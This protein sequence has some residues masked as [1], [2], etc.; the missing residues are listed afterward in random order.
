VVEL[1]LNWSY[2]LLGRAAES[3]K[4]TQCRFACGVLP[5][6]ET[7]IKGRRIQLTLHRCCLDLPK[8]GLVDSW[9]DGPFL[10]LTAFPGARF[11]FGCFTVIGDVALQAA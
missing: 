4:G 3:Q 2:I 8:G 9:H 5:S 11:A 1:H 6:Q 7:L 10:P